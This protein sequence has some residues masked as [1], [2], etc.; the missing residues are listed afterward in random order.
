MEQQNVIELKG[1]AQLV[2]AVSL[3]LTAHSREV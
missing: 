2:H 3:Y 1:H